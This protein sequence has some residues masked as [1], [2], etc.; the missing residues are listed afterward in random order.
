MDGMDGSV[1]IMSQFSRSTVEVS[2]L[3]L[4]GSF[5]KSWLDSKMNLLSFFGT[6]K[7]LVEGMVIP[8]DCR[9]AALADSSS[10]FEK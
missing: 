6:P 8:R 5:Q 3:L 10:L 7:V 2:S 4:W 1:Y 9:G